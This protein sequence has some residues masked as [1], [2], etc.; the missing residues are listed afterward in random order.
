MYRTKQLS[1]IC[2]KLSEIKIMTEEKADAVNGKMMYQTQS[3]LFLKKK[4]SEEKLNKA[5]L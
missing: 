4:S 2:K 3:L 5:E 1:L